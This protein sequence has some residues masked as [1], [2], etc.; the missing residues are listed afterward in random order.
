METDRLIS[1]L[2]TG[3]MVGGRSAKTIR[4]MIAAGELPNPVYV[5]RT[6]MLFLSDVVSY[7][8]KLK[9]KRKVRGKI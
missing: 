6:P 5:G 4:R 9:E 8:E 1:L 3:R 2:E 7:M